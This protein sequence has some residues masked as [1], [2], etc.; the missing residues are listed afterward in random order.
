MTI[1]AGDFVTVRV[2][3]G[4]EKIRRVVRLSDRTAIITT[5][6][7]FERAAAEG[8]EPFCIG[9]PLSDVEKGGKNKKLRSLSPAAGA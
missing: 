6:E 1:K 9:F 2:F 5:A 8:R 7:E 3:G 4:R